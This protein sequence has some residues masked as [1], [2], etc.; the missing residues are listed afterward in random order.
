MRTQ[1]NPFKEIDRNSSNESSSIKNAKVPKKI[2]VFMLTHTS[3][4]VGY[5]SGKLEILD[6]AF[7]SLIKN[8]DKS[9]YDFFVLDNG[10][11]RKTAEYLD[12]QKENDH[13]DYLMS[14]KKNLGVCNGF[15]MLF[16]AAP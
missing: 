9:L 13:I 11:N 3:D 5:Y 14:S 7:N 6:I 12:D 10:S 16:S 15:S 8:T 2:T 1:I 4:S